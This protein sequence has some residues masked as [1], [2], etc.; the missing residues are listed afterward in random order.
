MAP[1]IP[2]LHDH[3]PPA[4]SL[5]GL[6]SPSL[7]PG[8]FPLPGSPPLP[9]FLPLYLALAF[10][11]LPPKPPLA[12]GGGSAAR[13]PACLQPPPASGRPGRPGPFP[14][15]RVGG[16]GGGVATSPWRAGR[17]GRDWPPPGPISARNGRAAAGAGRGPGSR[18]RAEGGAES[19]ACT[20]SPCGA[21]GAEPGPPRRPAPRQDVVHSASFVH[22]E[23]NP[24]NEKVQP[25]L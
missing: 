24:K 19:A 5:C 3:L 6:C 14:G 25:A 9:A 18:G 16:G 23:Q 17:P 7:G 2:D 8:T 13:P 15:R 21:G 12:R 20:R 22:L 11:V 4:P 10:P 1:R